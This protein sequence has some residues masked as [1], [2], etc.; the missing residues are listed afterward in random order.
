MPN[1]CNN[2][3]RLTHKHP[4]MITRAYNAANAGT[5][6]HEFIPVPDELKG[7][8]D[9]FQRAANLIKHG[10]ESSYEFCVHEWGTKWDIMDCGISEVDTNDIVMYFDTAWSPPIVAYNVLEDL[11]FTVQALYY[12]GSMGF[13]GSYEN[14]NDCESST[15][16]IDDI[17]ANIVEA[18]GIEEHE[19]H[20]DE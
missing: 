4:A 12:E 11:G 13:C 6:L 5:L 3:L 10:Y 2:Q 9:E 20:E 19:E 15:D 8:L 1:Y 14:G 7:S 16:D 17:P 18:F